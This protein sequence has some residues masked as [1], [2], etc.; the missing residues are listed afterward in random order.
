MKA[1]LSNQ[2]MS[3]LLRSFCFL[4][5]VSSFLNTFVSSTQHLCHSDQQDALLEFK[6]EFS[7]QKPD[8]VDPDGSSYPK[9]ESWVNRSDCCSWD[10]ITCDAT[11][12]KVIGLDLSSSHLKGQLKSNSS[13]FRLRDLRDLNLARNNFNDSQFP[14]EFDKL[15]EL[16]RLNL[17]GSSLS[18]QIPINL[19]QLTK[20]VSLDLSSY[21]SLSIDESFL[22]LLA[23]NL[24]NLREL[25]MSY[26]NISSEI[27]HEFSNLRSLR[28]LDLTNCN[29]SG[30]FPSSVLLIPSLES[31][32][33]SYNSNM[34]GNLPV[35][36]ENNSLVELTVMF[37]AFSGK[38]PFSL[39]N[40]SHLSILDLSRNNFVGEIPS[41]IGN[42]KQLTVFDVSDNKLN[43][44]LPVSILNLTQLRRLWLSSNQFTGA[45]LSSLLKI[46][47]LTKIYLSY[48][49]FN[50]FIGI[51]NISLFLPNLQVFFIH[52]KNYNKVIGPGVDFNVFSPLKQLYWLSLSGIPLSTT[53]ITSDLDFLPKLARLFL[54]GC[55]I[56]E[57]PEFI[58][59]RRKLQWLDLSNNKIKGQVPDWLWRLPK[60]SEVNLSNNSLSGFNG[61]SKV[62]P[63]SQIS[64][65]DLSS[66]AFQGPLFIPSSKDLNYFW[67]SKNN[68]TGEIPRSVCG[69][70]SLAVLDLSN[71][72]LNGSIPRCLETLVMSSLSDLNLRNNKLSGILPEIFQN[73][74]S[75]TTLDF[76][77]NRL[78]GKMPASLVDCSALEVLNVGSNTFNDIFPFHLNSLQKLQVLV[79][80]SN[81][82]HGTLHNSDGVWFGFPQLKIIDVSHNDFFGTLP[83]HYFLNWTAMSSKSDDNI[84]PEY[85]TG[86][87]GNY[88]SL[89][90]MS[91]G[92]SMEMERILT[93]FTAIDFS[94]N[95]LNG[96]IPDSIGLLKELRILNMSSNAFTGHI[97]STLA[98]LTNLESLDLSQNKISGEIPSELGTLSS[99]EVINVSHNQL[100]GSI[101]QGTQFQ[102]QNCSSYEGNPGLNGPSLKDVC[103]D[104]KTP[105]P[106]QSELMESKEEEEEESFS[107]MAADL[108][109]APGVV[110]GLVMGYIAVSY[111]HEWFMK[112]FGRNKQQSIRTR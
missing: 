66:N 95:Q 97:P 10:G 110:F 91:K 98:N 72:N 69:L 82:F 75:L 86:P 41:S 107:W 32:R 36:R 47:S 56:T 53:N 94:G 89:V 65:V 34:R 35:F 78:E 81:K 112:R 7:I 71:N 48:N 19:L 27:P 54:R 83:S 104:I 13:L 24:R 103:R 87:S 70:S 62:S 30:E 25:D 64:N 67:G 93:I 92:V 8:W 29:L 58:R 109:F 21:D 77:H 76:S 2:K 85:I 23:Q 40:L 50:D 96:P 4:F 44:N 20:L 31:I 5:L 38:I 6:S 74:K 106:P 1:F 59:N 99:L 14:A 111:K 33:L 55:N 84:E 18:G 11:S 105:T 61:S 46:P 68:F 43:G 73:A 17:S 28:L 63:E 108:G 12:G 49:D 39:G 57:F 88:F 101:P 3:L 16:K 90:L 26:V 60:L 15:M 9:T 22:H 42:L 37:T 100:V 51:G 52:N 79:I 102:R 45:I 80:R